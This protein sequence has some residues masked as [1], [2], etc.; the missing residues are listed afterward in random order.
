MTFFGLFLNTYKLSQHSNEMLF[1]EENPDLK[2]MSLMIEIPNTF[3]HA[4]SFLELMSKFMKKK[5]FGI[6]VINE[7]I[8]KS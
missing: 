4:F 1:S 3:F 5:L 7:V 6:S 8:F 2:I